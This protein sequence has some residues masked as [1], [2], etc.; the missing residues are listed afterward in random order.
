M[1]C[2]EYSGELL[3]LYGMIDYV[4]VIQNKLIPQ[5]ESWCARRMFDVSAL[6]ELAPDQI[7]HTRAGVTA[8]PGSCLEL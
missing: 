6:W 1:F 3:V 2:P 7:M 4:E 8:I 5:T